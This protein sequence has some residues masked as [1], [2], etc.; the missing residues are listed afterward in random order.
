MEA[1]MIKSVK[2]I[3]GDQV[4]EVKWETG[5]IQVYPY[6]WLRDNCPCRT[7]CWD[8]SGQSPTAGSRFGL[9]VEVIANTVEVTV[10]T[11][12]TSVVAIEWSDGHKS[13]YLSDWLLKYK[14][15]A[16]PQDP[17]FTPKLRY[18]GAD[19]ARK[20]VK[21]Y[22]FN[23]LLSSDE[24]LLNWMTDLKELGIALVVNTPR[25]PEQLRLVGDRV[26]FLHESHYG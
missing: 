8:K 7:V 19:D 22:D 14:F 5:N 4:L 15:D 16:S 21:K 11:P 20:L 3:S 1:S 6:V 17:I 26:N 12:M 25:K 2:Q 23:D 10:M 24:I 13:Q 9:D 18:W